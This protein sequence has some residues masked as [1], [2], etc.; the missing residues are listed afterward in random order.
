M[1]Q[2]FNATFYKLKKEKIFILVILMSFGLALFEVYRYRT[3]GIITIDRIATEYMAIYFGIVM[4]FFVTIFVGKEYTEGGIR[5]KIIWGSKRSHIY[6]TNLM[7]S[8]FVRIT[9]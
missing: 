4:A 3:H 7:I 2:L 6:L 9:C 8:I 1:I 5:N